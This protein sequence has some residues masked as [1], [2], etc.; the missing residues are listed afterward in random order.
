MFKWFLVCVCV[1]AHAG[2]GACAVSEPQHL[3]DLV[4]VNEECVEKLSEGLISHY[5]P[6]LQRSRDTLQELT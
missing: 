1:C 2:A 3:E 6:D 4:L 5:L